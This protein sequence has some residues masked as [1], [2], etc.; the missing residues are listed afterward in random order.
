[1]GGWGVLLL[2]AVATV[3]VL[4]GVPTVLAIIVALRRRR[5]YGSVSRMQAEARVVDKRSLIAGG[6]ASVD[7]RYYV[8]FQFPDGNRVELAVPASEA[9]MLIVGDGGRLEWQGSSYLGFARE[10][11]R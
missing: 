1:M 9:G 4:V 10:I 7:Q 8:T 6:G 11:M 3:V 2:M 5:S